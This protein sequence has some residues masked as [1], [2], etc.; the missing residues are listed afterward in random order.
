MRSEFR[1]PA[2]TRDCFTVMHVRRQRKI[3][4]E[5][6]VRRRAWDSAWARM[7]GFR[8]RGKKPTSI[9]LLF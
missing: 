2:L 6:T 4:L 9:S 5:T 3:Q 1:N 7:A 8:G